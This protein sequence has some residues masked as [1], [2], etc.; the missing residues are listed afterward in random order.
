M[1]KKVLKINIVKYLMISCA[2]VII[3][4]SISYLL[5]K[6]MGF[7]YLYSTNSGIFCGF[8]FQYF[9]SMNFV[10]T[11]NK[12]IKSFAVYL[13]TFLVG[14]ALANISI[15]FSFDFLNLSFS[16]SKILSI[17]IPFFITYF[18]R[19]RTLGVKLNPVKVG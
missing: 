1:I 7:N 16:F 15:W 18:I 6:K 13:T 11:N 9:T 10:F 2:S 19:K 17:S 8:I 3:D 14:L 4:F 12:H 5:Y